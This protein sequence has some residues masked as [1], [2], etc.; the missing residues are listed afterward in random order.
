AGREG[1]WSMRPRGP[2]GR[3]ASRTSRRQRASAAPRAGHEKGR[4]V[5]GPPSTGLAVRSETVRQRQR[6]LVVDHV[7]LVVELA[8][9][10]AKREALVQ[11]GLHADAVADA[12]TPRAEVGRLRAVARVAPAD[13]P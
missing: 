9:L 13:E 11:R 3:R 6:R 1:I 2:E 4:P 8:D 7:L 12:V 10:G 5:A